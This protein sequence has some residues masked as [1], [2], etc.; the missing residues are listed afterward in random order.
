MVFTDLPDLA[1]L[2]RLQDG[3]IAS[4]ALRFPNVG[5][6]YAPDQ[7]TVE[8][9]YELLRF[10]IYAH[11]AAGN[12]HELADGGFTNWTQQ[13]LSDHKERLLISGIATERICA[14]F[15]TEPT[16]V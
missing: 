6:E 5:L 15:Y 14:Q 8:S 11:D 7:R 9:Y 12:R 13:V 16:D 2:Q 10:H 3:V 1:F 4:L